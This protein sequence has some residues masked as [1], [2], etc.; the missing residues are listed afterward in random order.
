MRRALP[1]VGAVL[2]ALC[3]GS[4]TGCTSQT[5][6]ITVVG[7]VVDDTDAVAV[8]GIAAPVVDTQ[9]GFATTRATSAP[10]ADAGTAMELGSRYRLAS[11]AVSEGDHVTTGDVVA[12]LDPA[13]LKD[14]VAIAEANRTAAK[15]QVAALGSSIDT[16]DDNAQTIKDN[17]TKVADAIATA[18]DAQGQLASAEAQLV[19][20]RKQ[21]TAKLASTQQLL[22]HYPPVAPAGTPTPAQ[23]TAAVAQLQ[24]QLATVNAKLTQVRAQQATL[25]TKLADARQAQTDLADAASTLKDARAQLVDAKSLAAIAVDAADLTVDVARARLDQT[26]LVATSTGT[27]LSVATAGSQLAAGAP[28]V[29][30]RPDEPARLTAWLAP[31]QVTSVCVGDPVA[32]HGDWMSPDETTDATLTR[33]GTEWQYPP[34]DV[35]TDEIHLTR[36]VEVEITTTDASLPAGVPADVTIDGCQTAAPEENG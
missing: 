9:A 4:L 22:A 23:L 2:V 28:V 33:I 16:V 31:D 32:V 13:A 8:P 19:S 7:T 24:T 20:A 35:P 34:T 17:Q 15:A 10:T 25:T 5:S 26:E 12:T 11:V 21:L 18:T 36:A 1:I 3:T 27:V 6:T 14:A 29:V 30:I